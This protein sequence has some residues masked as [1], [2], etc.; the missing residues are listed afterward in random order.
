MV[1]V[2]WSAL[3]HLHFPSKILLRVPFFP[4]LCVKTKKSLSEKPMA[5]MLLALGMI[6]STH[7][8]VF[9]KSFQKRALQD[10]MMQKF[11]SGQ[12]LSEV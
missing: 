8:A 11:K 4:S 12:N 9:S 3:D 10:E 2:S 6:N 7:F 1:D 5:E